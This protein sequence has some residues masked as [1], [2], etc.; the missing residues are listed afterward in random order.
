MRSLRSRKSR[1]GGSFFGLCPKNEPHSPSRASE[2]SARTSSLDFMY[3]FKSKLKKISNCNYLAH[4]SLHS[5]KG[6][7][8]SFFGLCPKTNHLSSL[9]A[10]SERVTK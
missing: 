4:S 5:Q 10:R 7:C 8:G 1:R 9:R 6:E 3:G 2:A